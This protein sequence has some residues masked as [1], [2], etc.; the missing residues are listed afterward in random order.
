MGKYLIFLLLANAAWSQQIKEGHELLWEISGNGLKE[1]SYLFGS[2]H[3]NDKRV[4]NLSDSTYFALNAVKA[5]ALE[6]NV[7]SIFDT[8]DTRNS[9]VKLQYDNDG[10]PYTASSKS[11]TTLYGDEDGMPQFLD[12]YFQQYC[13]NAGKEFYP[14]ESVEFQMDLLSDFSFPNMSEMR[15]EALLV[16]KENVLDLYLDGDIYGVDDVLKLNLSLSEGLYESLIVER[17]FGMT[18]QLDSILQTGASVFCAVGAGHL[19]GGSGM[20][21]LLRSKGY[22]MRKV[23]ASFSEEIAIEKV[24][25]QSKRYYEYFNDSIGFSARFYGM[26]L[27]VEDEFEAFDLKLIYRDLGQGNTYCIEVIPRDNDLSLSELAKIYIASPQESP[28]VKVTLSNGGEAYEGI[29]DSY[30]EGLSWTRVMMGEDHIMVL[31]TFGGNKFMN[32]SRPQ[33]FFDQVWF[34]E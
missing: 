28:A 16:S 21:N 2:F 18:N 29:S 23:T 31:K 17:N 26:P 22:E 13:H 1:K 14:L 34:N 3:S 11:T 7:F 30:P 20:I 33:K 6:T 5:V 24:E 19:A 10:K 27:A 15:M 4:F 32:S 25:V 9:D 8:W 12:G